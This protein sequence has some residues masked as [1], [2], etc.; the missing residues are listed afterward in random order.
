VEETADEVI[1]KVVEFRRK[2]GLPSVR[3]RDAGEPCVEAVE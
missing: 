1:A 3:Q 2:I